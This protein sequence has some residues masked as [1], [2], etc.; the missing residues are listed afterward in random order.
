MQWQNFLILVGTV[1]P[2]VGPV[3]AIRFAFCFKDWKRNVLLLSGPVITILPCYFY[4]EV[5]G[6]NG[7]LLF[8]TLFMLAVVFLV[9]YYP[10][11][12]LLLL[13]K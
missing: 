13:L 1:L 12:I 6:N 5:I 10:I 9:I 7:N 8:V 3:L 2:L 4:A 11:L